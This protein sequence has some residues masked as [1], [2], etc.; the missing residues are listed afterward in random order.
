MKNHLLFLLITIILLTNASGLKSIALEK[1]KKQV[2]LYWFTSGMVPTYTGRQN[3]YADEILISGCP[4]TGPL[5]CEDG[6][7][8]D[9]LVLS[10]DP[11]SGLKSSATINAF[12]TKY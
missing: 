9:D 5:H 2:S 7:D 3:T 1:S 4:N 6:F 12:I 10:G 8:D 11:Y